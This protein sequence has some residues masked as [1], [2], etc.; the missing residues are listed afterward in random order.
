M[1]DLNGT[2]VLGSNVSITAYARNL[3]NKR[4]LPDNWNVATVLKGPTD[5]QP[6]VVVSQNTLSDP[7]TF[8]LILNVKY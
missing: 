7:R 8:G 3:A 4:Y 5:S 1:I 6:I 2:L